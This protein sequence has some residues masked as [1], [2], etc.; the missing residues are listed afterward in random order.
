VFYC[1]LLPRYVCLR[2]LEQ[3][4]KVAKP[5]C[6][7]VFCCPGLFVRGLWI[8]QKCC[9]TIVFYSILLPG[10]VCQRPV[11]QCTS[12]ANPLCFTIFCCLWMS[13]RGL[14]IKVK[15]LQ[16]PCVLQCSVAQGCLSETFRAE[17]NCCKTIVFYSILLPG[18]VCQRPLDQCKN[19]AKPLSF[20]VFCWPV[21][22]VRGMLINAQVL[23][24]H[25]TNMIW[26]DHWGIE[27][28]TPL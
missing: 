19:V 7:T 17:Q 20:T 16:N 12:A 11:D 26:R 28:D 2:P 14:R 23:Q 22:S 15:R 21:L 3:Y 9:K 18:V 5:L 27:N 1:I 6:F 8:N 10:V 25:H 4:K 24:I 13:V